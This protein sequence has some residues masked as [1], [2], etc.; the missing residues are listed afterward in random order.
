MV[1][2]LSDRL[3]SVLRL[4]GVS[5]AEHERL[6]HLMVRLAGL[7]SPPDRFGCFPRYDELM[8]RFLGAVERGV[9]P[10]IEERFLE[11]YAHLHMNEA[12]YTADERL[13][14]DRSGGY[15]C[16]A[17]GLS[18]I[19]KAGEWIRT[20]SVTADLGA[21]NGLQAML[22]QTLYPH[23]RSHLIEISN[24]MAEIGHD[25]QQWLQIP[26]DRLTWRVEDILDAPTP[27]V[28]FLYLYRPVRPEGPGRAYYERLAGELEGFSR[29]VVVFSIA[30]C[31]GGFLSERFH[32]FYTDGHL[33]C[34][35]RS[36]RTESG[37][38]R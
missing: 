19:L 21:G 28:D 12:P 6:I 15:W 35:Q 3:A 5:P 11:V 10:D 20:G 38:R 30:D 2:A 31:L 34:F 36:D 24:R 7:G 9:A 4:D 23:R 17:G 1:A 26:A 29:P 13:Q 27:E 37:P 32:V 16:H 14:V 18:P 22:L 25:L 33:T 8:D